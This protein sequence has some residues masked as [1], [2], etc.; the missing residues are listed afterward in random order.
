LFLFAAEKKRNGTVTF[1]AIVED[2]AIHL[3][4]VCHA[5]KR[6]GRRMLFCKD[7]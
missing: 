1:K 6:V 3:K 7:E 5:Y 2:S 4:Q